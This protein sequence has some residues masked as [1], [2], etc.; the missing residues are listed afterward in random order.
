MSLAALV[1][2]SVAI[3]FG[4]FNPPTRGHEKLLQATQRI[5]P[6][7]YI[8]FASP[9][10]DVK[11]NPLP[12]EEKAS[13]LRSL[14][15]EHASHIVSD[16]GIRSILAAL[17][18]CNEQGHT[19]ITLVVGSDRV[20][21]LSALVSKYNGSKYCFDA[22][23]VVSAGGREDMPGVSATAA[24]ECVKAD[25]LERFLSIAPRASSI[26][27]KKSLFKSLRRR[28]GFKD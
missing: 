24:R 25:N 23:E 5:N 18:Y 12:L 3:T 15:P 20:E 6:S 2:S 14:F 13:Y 21:E 8:V 7:S 27:L 19:S 17:A 26:R 9:S 10:C 1:P 28:M 16:P 11:R 4:R 22:I